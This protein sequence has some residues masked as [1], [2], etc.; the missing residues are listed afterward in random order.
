MRGLTG[1]RR[2]L[3][4]VLAVLLTACSSPA[5]TP[6]TSKATTAGGGSGVMLVG[7]IDT[8]GDF[9]ITSAFTARPEMQ[10]GALPTPAPAGTTCAEY[11]NGVGN[12]SAFVSPEIHTAGNPNVYVRVVVSPG[13]AG[14]GSYTTENAPGLTGAA[15]VSIEQ[16]PGP[17]LQLYNSRHGGS[18]TLTVAADGSGTLTFTRWG[19]DEVRQGHIAGHL[20][21]TIRWE[22]R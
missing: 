6:S 1:L 20:W 10:V 16:G 8:T 9:N 18:T 2:G 22:C 3:L 4:P 14:P 12:R 19:T 21:G 17:A 15:V 11:A 13:Y 7:S 5:Q